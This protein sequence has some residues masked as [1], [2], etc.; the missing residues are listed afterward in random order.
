[1]HTDTPTN[2]RRAGR[3]L[4]GRLALA[5]C[6]FL[7]ACGG[8]ADDDASSPS[9]VPTT[10]AP[11]QA[12]TAP[13]VSTA[14]PGTAEVGVLVAHATVPTLE[15]FDAP[16][17]T[18]A[19]A[20]ALANPTEVGGPLVFL[21]EEER[22]EWLHVLLPVRPNGS[23]GWIRRAD[24]ELRHN[25]YSIVVELGAHR[26]TVSRADEVVAQEPIGVGTGDTPTPGGRYYL[27]ELLRPPDPN[28]AYGPYAYG[29]SGF[30]EVLTSFANGEGVIGIHGTNDPSSIGRDVSHGCIRL[31][32]DAI[33]RLVE[34]L[35]LGTPV[36]IRA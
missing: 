24:V 30:S 29:L 20:R 14:P 25:P 7:A 23:T 27:K 5:C 16:D 19:P 8:G 36:E 33:T 28:G 2:V 12:Q 10:A 6:L 4:V 18:G 35:P 1:M 17:G 31:H 11:P 21:V 32:N 15:V 3:P 9:A 22:D 34:Y 26:I 13:T